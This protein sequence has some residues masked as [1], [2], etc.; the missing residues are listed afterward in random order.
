MSRVIF[1]IAIT[2]ILGAG[3]GFLLFSLLPNLEEMWLRVPLAIVA[4]MSASLLTVIFFT[5]HDQ[6]GTTDN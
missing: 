3:G 6:R 2:A 1:R 4:G 5:L